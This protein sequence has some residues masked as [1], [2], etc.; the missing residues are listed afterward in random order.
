MLSQRTNAQ[1]Y[2]KWSTIQNIQYCLKGLKPFCTFEFN[3]YKNLFFLSEYKNLDKKT[4]TTQ[5]QLS[6]MRTKGH[7]I[8]HLA[9][10][11]AKQM[12]PETFMPCL[13]ANS[14]FPPYQLLAVIEV[15]FSNHSYSVLTNLFF[16]NLSYLSQ[17]TLMEKEV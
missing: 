10:N 7:L 3:I 13:Q 2:T 11:M 9:S 16:L 5:K 12:L 1:N 15:P 14:L 17:R 8:Q 6:Y 4:V